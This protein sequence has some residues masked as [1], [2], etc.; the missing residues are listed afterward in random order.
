SILLW[1]GCVAGALE[2]GEYRE[3]LVSAGFE[4]IDLEPTRIYRVADALNFLTDQGI[5]VAVVGPQVD[6]KFISAFIRARK[7]VTRR[8]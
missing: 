3:K 8:P 1:V 2:E 4:N 6:E 7:P 5:D